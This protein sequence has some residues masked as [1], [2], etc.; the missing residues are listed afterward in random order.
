MQKIALP[1][2]DF[3]AWNE[4]DKGLQSAIWYKKENRKELLDARDRRHRRNRL[5]LRLSK[6]LS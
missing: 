5:L 1:G 3:K 4:A 2:T 6:S